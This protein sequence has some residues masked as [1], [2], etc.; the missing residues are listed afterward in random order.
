MLSE[1]QT[2]KPVIMRVDNDLAAQDVLI[3]AGYKGYCK[4]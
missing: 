3:K 2:M 4:F 1:H